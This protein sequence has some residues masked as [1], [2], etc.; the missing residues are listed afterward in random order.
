MASLSVIP[1]RGINLL[2]SKSNTLHSLKSTGATRLKY[3]QDDA[4]IGSFRKSYQLAYF[5]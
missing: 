5:K 3:F 2:I 1:E 4:S